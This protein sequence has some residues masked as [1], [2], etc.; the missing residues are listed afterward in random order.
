MG[1][2]FGVGLGSGF[3]DFD[4]VVG[5]LGSA[6]AVDAGDDGDPDA[7]A[8]LP[9]EIQIAGQVLLAGIRTQV[10]HLFRVSRDRC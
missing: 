5:P 1:S 9:D 8:A 10:V 4:G 2:G 6:F 7:V 3:F